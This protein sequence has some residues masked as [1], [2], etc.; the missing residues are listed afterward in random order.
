VVDKP[1]GEEAEEAWA[2]LIPQPHVLVEGVVKEHEESQRE[3]LHDDCGSFAPNE[4]PILGSRKAVPVTYS[5]AQIQ[6]IGKDFSMRTTVFAVAIAA[7]C[8]ASCFS[9]GA[10]DAPTLVIVQPGYPGSTKDAE[11]F[12][13]KLSAYVEEKAGLKGLFGEYHN[14]EKGALAAVEKLKPAFGV[15]SVGFYLAHRKDLGLKPL[16]QSKPGDNFVLVARTGELKDLAALKGQPVAGGPLHER[17]YLERVALAGKAD[18][19]VWDSKPVLQASRAL[20]D[21]VDRKNTWRS[22]SPGGITGPSAHFI[23]R[24]LWRKS[25]SPTTIHPLFWWPSVERPRKQ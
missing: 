10:E 12:I 14:D 4:G 1:G 6:P 2:R 21:L 24:I 20:R 22:S 18:P 16:L 19:A 23:R 15:V 17:G 25:S 13:R 7:A 11:G 3:L 5:P 8:L 9:A